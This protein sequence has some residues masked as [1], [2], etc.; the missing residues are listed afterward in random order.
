MKWKSYRRQLTKIV[1]VWGQKQ[2]NYNIFIIYDILYYNIIIIENNKE[3]SKIAPELKTTKQNKNLP[4]LDFT[5]K[6]YK[7]L[8]SKPLPYY[9]VLKSKGTFKYILLSITS[10]PKPDEAA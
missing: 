9:P 6:F 4:V 5:G 2:A 8:Q 10:I 7:S 3:N 1:L